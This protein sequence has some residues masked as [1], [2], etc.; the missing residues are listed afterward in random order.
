MDSKG[1]HYEI[2]HSK[3]YSLWL[4]RF[5][6]HPCRGSRYTLWLQFGRYVGMPFVYL[7]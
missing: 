1:G 2:L 6:L 7:R 4:Y 5:K 3:Y